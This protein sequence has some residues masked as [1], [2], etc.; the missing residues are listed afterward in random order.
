[1]RMEVVLAAML[2]AGGTLAY[3]EDCSCHGIPTTHPV[4]AG[5]AIRVTAV[6]ATVVTKSGST[7]VDLKASGN[8]N[9]G[10]VKLADLVSVS[11]KVVANDPDDDV[12][13]AGDADAYAKLSSTLK[14]SVGGAPVAMTSSGGG[15]WVATW[16]PSAAGKVR[17]SI[18]GDVKDDAAQH[19][20]SDDGDLA[21]SG[22][23]SS[24]TVKK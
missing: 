8:A 16:T 4:L 23:K 24:V 5:G 11:F 7:V 3:S 22:Y 1:M 13:E 18:A 19:A 2:V 20:D 12:C 14:L 21:V 9:L 17:F 10:N 15:V 6:T